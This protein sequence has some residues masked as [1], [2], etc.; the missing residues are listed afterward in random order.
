MEAQKLEPFADNPTVLDPS[1]WLRCRSHGHDR[2]L[3]LLGEG[4]IGMVH[5]NGSL[6]LGEL[7]EIHLGAKS[8]N[9]TVGRGPTGNCRD[10]RFSAIWIVS[11]SVCP[12]SAHDLQSGALK[13]LTCRQT[14]DQIHIPLEGD[15][16]V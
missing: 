2:I 15:W 5:E 12:S 1:G 10:A 8:V 7:E 14:A 3:R 13:G 11:G 9:R 16:L 4:G 6:M